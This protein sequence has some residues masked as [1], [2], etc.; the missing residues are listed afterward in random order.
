L[1]T[2]LKKDDDI[3]RAPQRL[4]CGALLAA[5]YEYNSIPLQQHNLNSLIVLAKVNKAEVIIICC[6]KESFDHIDLPDRK[7]SFTPIYAAMLVVIYLRYDN[8]YFPACKEKNSQ[9]SN[10]F[11]TDR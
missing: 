1:L 8:T 5:F 4:H 6:C 3:K 7:L 2:S 10:V 9:I 11:T